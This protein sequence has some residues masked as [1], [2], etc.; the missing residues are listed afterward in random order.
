[1]NT[2]IN[3]VNLIDCEFH[4]NAAPLPP[5]AAA[6]G[7]HFWGKLIFVRNENLHLFFSVKCVIIEFV[8]NQQPFFGMRNQ[9]TAGFIMRKRM[10]LLLCTSVF[11]KYYIMRGF[12][13]ANHD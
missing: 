1:M 9:K 11:A 7:N 5:K 10:M 13:P 6:F 3:F 4:A 8:Y 12:C 2:E